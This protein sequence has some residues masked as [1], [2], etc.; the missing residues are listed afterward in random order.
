MHLLEENIVK[1]TVLPRVVILDFY[2]LK[3]LDKKID[4]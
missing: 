3:P 1:W 4:S 2:L